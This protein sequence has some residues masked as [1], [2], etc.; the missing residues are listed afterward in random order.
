MPKD[1]ATTPAVEAT[2]LDVY[3]VGER[4]AQEGTQ[5]QEDESDSTA[6][7][8][9]EDLGDDQGD[10]SDS[11]AGEENISGSEEGTKAAAQKEQPELV[12]FR[13]RAEAAENRL[14]ERERYYQSERDRQKAQ[15]DK[16]STY[17]LKAAEKEEEDAESSGDS[18]RLATAKDIRKALKEVHAKSAPALESGT[19]DGKGQAQGQ[20]TE[21]QIRQ[22]YTTLL[23]DTYGD[24]VTALNEFAQKHLASDPEYQK[25]ASPLRRAAYADR[26]RTER[27]SAEKKKAEQAR[28]K[29]RE[30][31]PSA[32][33]K[34]PGG[35]PSSARGRGEQSQLGLM[36]QT[37]VDLQKRLG[38]NRH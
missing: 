8:E 9:S 2:V 16:I 34:R 22:Q 4:T 24:D 17:L 25:I 38:Q 33:G 23:Y 28:V 15:L 13:R 35:V 7:E 21:E 20:L 3:G 30:R 12:E 31:I 6:E 26:K 37:V 27:K 11:D 19:G 18:D 29:E 14:I 10:A 36:A 32:S 1:Q 5:D